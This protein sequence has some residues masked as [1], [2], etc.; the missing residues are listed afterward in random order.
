MNLSVIILIKNN[1][2]VIGPCL[3]SIAWADEVVLV[4]T[5]STD[6]T[7]EIAK[8]AVADSKLKIVQSQLK[9]IDFSAWRNL[10]MKKAQGDWLLYLDSDERVNKELKEE[11][12]SIIRG[13]SSLASAYRLPRENYYFG[14]RVK[15]GG[16]WPDYVTRLFKKEALKGWQGIIHESPRFK[17]ELGILAKPLIHL[18]HRNIISGLKKSLQWTKLEAELFYQADHPAVAWWRLVKVSLAE[19]CR[20][21][22]ILQGWR[23]GTIG[24]IEAIVQAFNRFMV[25]VQLWEKQQ[26]PCLE[27]KYQQ[28]EEEIK[29]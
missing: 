4:D 17:G 3:E 20:R 29:E 15:H 7:L 27:K 12:K 1:Q 24:L 22:I 6:R 19:L 16:S 14:R 5:G 9:E 11:I 23:D 26:Q 25:Y 21:L 18:A 2:D 10:G 13:K 28:I 8:K